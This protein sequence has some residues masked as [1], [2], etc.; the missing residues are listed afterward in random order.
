MVGADQTILRYR[1]YNTE[2]YNH[3]KRPEL[4]FCYQNLL[5][6]LCFLLLNSEYFSSF[7]LFFMMTVRKTPRQNSI[8]LRINAMI[9]NPS[10]LV[11]ICHWEYTDT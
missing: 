4:Y 7:S 6:A 10:Y 11:S 2:A 3:Q 8:R 1:H 5:M 9:P